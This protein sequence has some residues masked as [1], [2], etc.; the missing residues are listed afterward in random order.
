M[1]F[2]PGECTQPLGVGLGLVVRIINQYSHP[3]RTGKC[4][5]AYTTINNMQE[6]S[7]NTG[8]LLCNVYMGIGEI[9]GTGYHVDDMQMMQTVKPQLMMS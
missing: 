1:I 4:T 2:R 7:R 9:T 8:Y 3:V 5:D 6:T